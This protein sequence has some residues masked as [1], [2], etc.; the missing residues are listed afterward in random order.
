MLPTVRRENRALTPFDLLDEDFGRMLRR[1]WGDAEPATFGTYPVDI[2]EDDAHIYIDA[3][4]PG[5]SKDEVDITLENG[6]LTIAAERKQEQQEGKKGQTHLRERL[7]TRVARR[8][9]I[10]NAVDEQKVQ[11][12]LRDGVLHLTLNKRE[13]V[14]PRK[15]EVK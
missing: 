15:I 2:H 5:F 4:L 3:D 14:K 12:E 7:V 13:E 11:A 6:V 9:S 8:F 1:W 10:P